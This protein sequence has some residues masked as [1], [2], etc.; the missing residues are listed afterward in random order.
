MVRVTLD[1]NCIE[2]SDVALKSIE[3]KSIN[4]SSKAIKMPVDKRMTPATAST[5][6]PGRPM[7]VVVNS[8][9]DVL[10]VDDTAFLFASAA[11]VVKSKSSRNANNIRKFVNEIAD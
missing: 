4:R 3:D 11:V 5:A 1:M 2:V 7:S 9:E 6:A 8:I 10:V